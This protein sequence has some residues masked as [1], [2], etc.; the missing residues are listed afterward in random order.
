[1][2]A[3]VRH[4]ALAALLILLAAGLAGCAKNGPAAPALVPYPK[5]GDVAVYELS[6]AY[7]ELSRW[8]NGHPVT[9][10]A[11][12]RVELASGGKMLDA[13]RLVH[14]TFRV[15]TTLAGAKFSDVYVS[16]AHEG[17]VQAVYPLS[18]DQNVVSFD[19]RGYP[20]LFGASALFG[21][22]LGPGAARDV[23]IPENLAA[24]GASIVI[25]PTL[26][27]VPPIAVSAQRG[28]KADGTW[29]FAS[30]EGNAT[31]FD[32]HDVPGVN[33]SVWLTASSAWPTRVHLAITSDALA[34]NVRVDGA[35]PAVMDAR[36]VSLQPGTTLLPPRDSAATFQDDSSVKRLA[37][38]GEKPPDGDAGYAAYT[39]G[40]AMRDAKVLDKG[41]RDWLAKAQDPRLYRATFKSAPLNA[42]GPLNDTLAPYWLLQWV[43]Q[44]ETYYQ[45]EMQRVDPPPPPVGPAPNATSATGIPRVLSSGPVDAPK[46]KAH[47]WFPREVEP[48][49]LVPL[50]EGVRVMR[51]VFGAQGVQ[52]FLRSFARPAGYSYFLDGGWDKGESA[53][54]TVVY[55]PSTGLLEEATGP[56]TARAAPSSAPS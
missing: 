13:A 47:G 28:L 42:T 45:V 56:V 7:V 31:R 17:I 11:Q 1:M 44:G 38:D 29:A 30:Q 53:R 19:E 20:W 32:L 22:P 9:A 18:Q 4:A 37:W 24:P 34:P 54:Y 43:D 55:N 27:G 16:P 46:D 33:G 39:L 21:T 15:T 35:L 23:I 26:P 51:S 40:D 52:I 8:E 2:D 12:L 5:L 6:G 36:L 49:E 25:A 14:D 10:G 48:A 3:F 50:S 41:L